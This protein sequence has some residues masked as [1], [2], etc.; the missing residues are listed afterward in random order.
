MIRSRLFAVALA[1]ALPLTLAACGGAVDA[2]AEEAHGH[3]GG[4]IVVTDYA[5]LTEL[6]VEFRPLVVGKNRRFDAHLT[7][8][9]DYKP[10]TKGSL[11]AELIWPDGSRDT[12]KVA[13]SDV[14]GIFRPLLKASKSGKA[15]LRLVLD[16]PRGVSAHDLG[17]VTVHPT[18]EAG[19]KAAP[20]ETEIEG[21]IAFTKEVQWRIRSMFRCSRRPRRSSLPR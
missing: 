7:W 11:T 14:E 19:A 3:G 13:P 16:S 10:V 1:A 17:E 4:G 2:P 21:A 20:P 6:F 8:L 12:A 9:G 15:R 5:E 18:S